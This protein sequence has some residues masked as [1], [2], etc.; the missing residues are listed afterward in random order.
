MLIE[1]IENEDKSRP[2][3]DS[4]DVITSSPIG[5]NNETEETAE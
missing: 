4:D 3:I 2:P 1:I 5:Q